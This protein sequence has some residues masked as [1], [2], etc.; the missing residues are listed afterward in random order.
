VLP[1]IEGNLEA[2]EYLR[3]LKTVFVP[4]EKRERNVRLLSSNWEQNTYHVTEEL[5]FYNGTHRIRLDVAFFINGI[6]VLLV[7]AKA[8][9]KLEGIAEALEQ[10]RRYHREAPELMALMQV[11]TLTHLIH[12]ITA[13][14]GTTHIN[15]CSTGETEKRGEKISKPWSRPSSTPSAD[16][17]AHRLTSSSP[18]KMT[19]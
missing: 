18:A 4:E 13:P 7:E 10:I 19:S 14:P 9:T 17:P 12:F 8:A 2:W 11:H 1:R 6:P 15:P 16:P 5:R 3:G